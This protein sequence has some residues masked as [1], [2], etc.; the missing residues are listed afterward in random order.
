MKINASK[1]MDFIQAECQTL[2][3]PLLNF[4]KNYQEYIYNFLKLYDIEKFKE[5]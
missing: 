4:H 3:N 5:I 1:D 2:Y